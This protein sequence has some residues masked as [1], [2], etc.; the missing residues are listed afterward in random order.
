LYR[1]DV[2]TVPTVELPPAIPLTFQIVAVFY[3]F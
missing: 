2:L 3:G 1:P